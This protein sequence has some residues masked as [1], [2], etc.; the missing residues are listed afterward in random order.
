LSKGCEGFVVQKLCQE[1]ERKSA[2]ELSEDSGFRFSR[3]G[4]RRI[5]R[6]E[7]ADL[8]SFLTLSHEDRDVLGPRDVR[9]IRSLYDVDGIWGRGVAIPG[10]CWLGRIEVEVRDRDTPDRASSAIR[11]TLSHLMC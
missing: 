3:V 9:E 8:G 4:V 11:T 5:V 7:V 2:S 10:S 1:R 6:T